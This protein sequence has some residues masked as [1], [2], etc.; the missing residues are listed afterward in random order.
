MLHDGERAEIDDVRP[1]V[2]ANSPRMTIVDAT[3]DDDDCLWSLQSGKAKRTVLAQYGRN[4]ALKQIIHLGTFR[5]V[6]L[7]LAEKTWTNC[8]CWVRTAVYAPCLT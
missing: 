1:F 5:A 3:I 2:H 4:G 7:A 8:Y 6:G